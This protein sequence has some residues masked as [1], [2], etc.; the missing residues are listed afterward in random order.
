MTPAIE[1]LRTGKQWRWRL[2]AS[3]G[4]RLC[5]PGE[6]FT[7]RAACLN[8]IAAVLDVQFNIGDTETADISRKF[9]M[10][11]PAK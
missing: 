7:R 5:T 6:S 9:K 10:K 8:N 1:I 4:R 3:N 2:V 11:W